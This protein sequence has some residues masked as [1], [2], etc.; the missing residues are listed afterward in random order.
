MANWKVTYT[1]DRAGG[2]TWSFVVQANDEESAKMRAGMM[3]AESFVAWF[4]REFFNSPVKWERVGVEQL[5]D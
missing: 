2:L 5:Q 1:H 3:R 4:T